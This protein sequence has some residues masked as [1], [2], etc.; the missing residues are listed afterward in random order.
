MTPTTP[1]DYPNPG[2]PPRADAASL[3]PATEAH[4]FPAREYIPANRRAVPAPTVRFFT[5]ALIASTLVAAV[6]CVLYITKPVVIAPPD[7]SIPAVLPEQPAAMVEKTATDQA[8]TEESLAQKPEEPLEQKPEE[9]TAAAD[10]P[11]PASAARSGHEETNLRVQHVLNAST[12]DGDLSRIVLD[13]PV[14]YASR[15]LR[16]THAE[17]ARAREIL[18]RLADYHEQSRILR[19]LGTE[20]LLD[21]NQLIEQSIPAAELRADSP[22]LPA[23]QEDAAPLPRPDALDSTESIKIRPSGP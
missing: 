23:N 14:I 9:S 17:I 6:F 7:G 1:P 8:A 13:V 5:L 20:I 22:S 12:A 4:T 2:D 11:T 3:A 18:N 21:W 15:N 16:W 19:D 10:K